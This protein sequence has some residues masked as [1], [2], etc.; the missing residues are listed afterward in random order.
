M[1]VMRMPPR[2]IRRQNEG[3]RNKADGVVDLRVVR[4]RSVS[5]VVPNAEDGATDEALEPP[6]SGPETP[7]DGRDGPRIGAGLG[8]CFSK[9]VDVLGQLENAGVSSLT[10]AGGG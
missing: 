7:L 4:E 6:V 9:R 3:M 1:Q 2:V 10:R 5:S 8:E